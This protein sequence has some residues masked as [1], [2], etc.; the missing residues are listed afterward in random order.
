MRIIRE[1][2]TLHVSEIE[3]LAA[4]NALNFESAVRAALPRCP[5]QINIDLSRTGFVDCG[6]LGAL[7]AV[8]NCA[9]RRNASATVRLLNPASSTRRLLTLA[10]TDSLFP[11]ERL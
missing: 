6:G 7:I 5:R 4:A 2:E 8:R 1:G 3:E 10:K 9:R 11:I